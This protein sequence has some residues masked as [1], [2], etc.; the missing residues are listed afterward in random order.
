[1]LCPYEKLA[2]GP[3]ANQENFDTNGFAFIFWWRHAEFRLR[4]PRVCARNSKRANRE[5][6]E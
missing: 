6:R 1:M 2:G 5:Q 3:S 4:G